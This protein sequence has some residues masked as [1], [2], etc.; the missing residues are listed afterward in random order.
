MV[1]G[2]YRFANHRLGYVMTTVLDLNPY[3]AVQQPVP[4][5][6][7]ARLEALLAWAVLS[8]SPHNTQP[9]SWRVRDGVI[10]LARDNSRLLGVSDPDGRE[11]VISCGSA[12]EH[13]LL[14]LGL[15]GEPVSVDLSAHPDDPAHLARITVGTGE[16]YMRRPDLVAQMPLRR[17]NRTAYHGHAMSESERSTLVDAC[18]AFGVQTLWLGD[19]A[20]RDAIVTVIMESDREQ[21]ADPAFRKELSHWMRPEHSHQMT[22]MEADLLG[23]KGAGAYVA[24][25]V[26]RTFDVG[27]MQAAKDEALTEG[28]PDLFVFHTAD[29][30]ATN[31][32]AMGRALAHFT[33]GAMALGRASAYMNQPCEVPAARSRVRELFGITGYP[34]LILRVGIADETHAALRM[35][36]SKVLV[37]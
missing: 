27:K 8:P 12:L 3:D 24:P 36:V 4:E 29:D 9:W 15:D 30:Q 21:M 18:S 17:T 23:Q 6:G 35:P 25:L 34:Q 1:S 16:P 5:S 13:L 26:V 11:L 14:R 20:Q 28:S 33:L 2:R 7:D 32:L 10:D 31:W 37:Q 22:G 19:A